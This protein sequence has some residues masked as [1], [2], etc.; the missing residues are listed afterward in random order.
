LPAKD[1]VCWRLFVATS[2][3]FP[4]KLFP[5]NRASSVLASSFTAHP[6]PMKSLPVATRRLA[7]SASSP[8]VLPTK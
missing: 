7:A 2:N 8:V 5:V 6:F 3:V 1:D 4:T